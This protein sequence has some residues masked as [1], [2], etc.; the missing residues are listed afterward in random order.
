MKANFLSHHP[1]PSSSRMYFQPLPPLISNL[2][3]MLANTIYSLLLNTLC[4]LHYSIDNGLPV[5]Q[6]AKPYKCFKA[7]EK[8][9][10]LITVHLILNCCACGHHSASEVLKQLWSQW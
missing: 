2:N 9:Q 8:H 5:L 1:E 7:K 3:L 10:L 4:T 6:P